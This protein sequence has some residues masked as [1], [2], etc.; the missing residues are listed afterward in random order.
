MLRH[1]HRV[2]AL[3]LTACAVVLGPV[4]TAGAVRSP[5]PG[6]D[7][8]KE[9]LVAAF[10]CYTSA[11]GDGFATPGFVLEILPGRRYRIPQGEGTFT[12]NP[13]ER[14]QTVR[15]TTGPLVYYIP[16]TAFFN[17]FGQ[18]LT[19]ITP[20][21]TGPDFNCYQQGPRNEAVRREFAAKD[22]QPGNY[23][24]VN[25][26][27]GAAAG[28][29]D[30][31]PG[32]RYAVDGNQGTFTVDLLSD[33]TRRWSN[34][35]FTAGPLTDVVATY[36]AD[37]NTGVRNLSVGLSPS[38]DCAVV[39]APTPNSRYGP[40]KAPKRPRLGKKVAIDGI[41][42]AWQVDVTGI[43]GGLCWTFFTFTSNGWVY[44]REPEVGRGDAACG[45]TYANGLT[46]CQRYRVK[47]RTIRIGDDP[48][49]SFARG[50]NLLKINGTTFRLVAPF[51]RG[52]RLTGAYR[53]QTILQPL[54][55]VSGVASFTT[56]TFTP[57]GRFTRQGAAGAFLSP[58]AGQPG[59]SVAVASQN[60]SAGSYRI[61]PGTNTVELRFDNK[62]VRQVFAFIPVN[63]GRFPHPKMIHFAGTDYLPQ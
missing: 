21:G 39:V 13:A 17:D 38:F 8:S 3:I 41:Y 42:A 43:C 49:V 31:L 18:S 22:P 32:H 1:R 54:P 50:K 62:A 44:T 27:T 2:R 5:Q 45:K 60:G 23:P 24:C 56:Y 26:Q 36:L 34:I 25:E 6:I 4:A 48:P 55:G 12:V 20:G 46:V 52:K 61:L 14:V 30:I 58:P 40:A 35:D 10:A 33:P 51:G 16:T 15:F 37:I 57:A 59:A 63:S 9:P 53:S 47:G 11:R 19:Q 28:S 29:I 7:P